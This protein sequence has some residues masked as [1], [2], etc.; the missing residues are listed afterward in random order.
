MAR[1][2]S[3]G[4]AVPG[5]RLVRAILATALVLGGALVVLLGMGALAHRLAGGDTPAPF[6]LGVV[7]L[8]LACGATGW[9]LGRGVRQA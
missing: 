6:G 7:A 2:P 3:S 8:G 5:A 4:A 9:L 1:S